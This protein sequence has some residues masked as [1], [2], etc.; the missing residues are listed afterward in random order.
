MQEQFLD[1]A[2]DDARTGFRLRQLE[3]L[4]WG[5]FHERAWRLDVRGENALLTGDIGSGKS[6]LV[7]AMTTLLVPAGRVAYNKAAGAGSR[8]RSLRSYVFGYYKSERSDAGHNARPVALRDHNSYSV[9]LAVFANAGF[10]QVVTLAQVFWFRDR[11]APPSRFYV[12][13]ESALAI[14]EHFAGFGNDLRQLRKRLRALPGV[15]LFDSFPPYEGAFRRLFGLDRDQALELFH[16]TVSMKSVG[17]LTDFVREHMLEAFDVTARIDALLAH[18][19]DLNRAHAAVLKARAQLE[20]LRPLVEA[21]DRHG[22]VTQACARW[23]S[24]RNALRPYFAGLRAGLLERRLERLATEQERLEARLVRQRDTLRQQQGERDR[25]RAAIAGH[26]G[27]RLAQLALE[28]E[29]QER[30]RDRRRAKAEHYAARSARLELS[31]P[32]DADGFFRNRQILEERRAASAAASAELDN[33]HTERA[34]AL[35]SARE[36]HEALERELVSLRERRSNLPARQVALRQR[37]CAAAGTGQGTAAGIDESDLPFAGEL[38]RVRDDA[39]AWE[40][41]AERVLHSFALSLLVPDRHYRAVA[42]WVEANHLAGRLVYFRVREAPPA[43]PPSLHPNSLVYKLE[44]RPDAECYGWM[45]QQLARRFDLACCDSLAALRR[46]P[47]ALTAAGHLKGAQERHEK[48]DRFPIDDR[49]RYVLGW[50]NEDKIHALE[51]QQAQLEQ[52]AQ[53]QAAELQAVAARRRA[54]TEERDA[55]TALLEIDAFDEIDWPAAARAAAALREERD[56]LEAASDELRS[57]S[58]R[59]QVLEEEIAASERGREALM[60]DLGGVEDR[61]K[62]AAA[63]L[64]EARELCAD[65]AE[66]AEAFA[67]LDG[68]RGEV[69]GD[70]ELTV[71]SCTGREQLF[72]EWLQARIDAEMKTLKRLEETILRAM[73]DY[74][75][76]WPLDTQEVDSSLGAADEY[77]GMLAQLEADDL[78]RFERRF[79]EL[80]NE[81]TIREVAAFQSQL[82]RERQLIRERIERINRSLASIEYNPGRYVVLEAESSADGEIRAFQEQ[83]RSCMEGTVTGSDDEHYAE[84]KFLQVKAIIERFRGREGLAE[85]DQRWTRKVTDVR[86]WFSFAASERYREDD[87]EYE[88]YTDSGGKSGGQKEKLAYT[89]LAASL[90]YQ[91]GIESGEVRSRSFRFVMIDEAFGRGSDES[92]RFGLELFQRLNLQL[93]IV[94]PLQKIHIIEPYVAQVGFVHNRDGRESMLR[95]LTIE[96]YRREREARSPVAAATDG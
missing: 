70:H 78:P 49:T 27:D 13:A 34:V 52:Q 41:A 91:F 23:E 11:D 71:E 62:T 83:L 26:G 80:L 4:N 65:E 46:E 89:V 73:A 72:R 64:A 67:G 75:H 19:D 39:A 18:F 66:H 60:R 29:Q 85:L 2:S 25:L 55:L 5:T 51:G 35:R 24:Y 8:E 74:R 86:Q 21:C 6:T 56:A 84:A 3:V 54:L 1:F 16:Q 9:L 87:T 28:L 42:Q 82:Q 47:R 43:E 58:A 40:G 68:L 61:S 10:D 59:L 77:R 33:E 63:Q 45:E 81:N 15:Q 36:Q 22:E 32:E 92:A 96:E 44:L 12:V 37:L 57:L 7:D 50:S 88:H 69:L 79:K 38:L 53:A 17:N 30:L 76:A 94:T 93:L 20:A 90:V 95:N 31:V 14:T 48:D